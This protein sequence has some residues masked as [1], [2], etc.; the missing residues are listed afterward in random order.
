MN[1]PRLIAAARRAQR[2]AYA[3]YSGLKVGAS[4][5][6]RGGRIHTGCNVENASYGESLCAERA[7]VTHAVARGDREILAVAVVTSSPYAVMPCGA[8]RQVIAEF[9]LG[10]KVVV[11]GA[12]GKPLVKAIREL[13]PHPFTPQD[14]RKGTRGA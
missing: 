7:C 14:L 6:C 13:L 2:N 8:C 4:V 11:V 10:I 3:P 5:L 12:E 1:I 9:G